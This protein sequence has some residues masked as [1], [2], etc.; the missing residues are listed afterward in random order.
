[1]LERP[2]SSTPIETPDG[3]PGFE[4]LC[5]TLLSMDVPDGYRAEIIG[6][7]IVM[8]P[9]S[10]G[11]YFGVMEAIRE[12]LRPHLPEGETCGDAP[13][14]F[15]FP[16][17][18]RAYGPDFYVAARNAF[19]TTKRYIDGD[20]LSLVAELTSRSTRTADWEDKLR[21]YGRTRVPVYLLLDMEEESATVFST[22]SAKGYTAH[23]TVPFG[24]TLHIPE[25]FGCELDTTGFAAPTADGGEQTEAG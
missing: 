4:A 10:K 11:Y 15:T 17:E 6:G 18:E 5:R 19:D 3:P 9:W 2:T 12:Q 16:G 13:F 8:S 23:T 14:L 20:A 25:P 21:V 1:M 24:K 7:N 22:P